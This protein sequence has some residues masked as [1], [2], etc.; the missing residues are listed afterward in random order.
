MLVVYMVQVRYTGGGSSI[1][2]ESMVDN[3]AR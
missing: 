1:I 2:D 3:A